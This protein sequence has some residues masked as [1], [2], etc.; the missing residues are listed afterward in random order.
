MSAETTQEKIE[1]T[2]ETTAEGSAETPEEQITEETELQTPSYQE[3]LSMARGTLLRNCISGYDWEIPT[4][5]N[6]TVSFELYGHA[7]VDQEENYFNSSIMTNCDLYIP[8][9]MYWEPV[10][11]D[12]FE[13]QFVCADRMKYSPE[14]EEALRQQ[15]GLSLE[16]TVD[17]QV[18][19]DGQFRQYSGE[20]ALVARMCEQIIVYMGE[21]QAQLSK[22]AEGVIRGE[23][24]MINQPEETHYSV[25]ELWICLEEVIPI[26]VTLHFDRTGDWWTYTK[27]F[28]AVGGFP[29]QV[30]EEAVIVINCD[31]V[32]EYKTSEEATD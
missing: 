21:L 32:V 27:N 30:R 1:A 12:E 28:N 8:G 31:L 5:E 15:P 6:E 7:A 3:I 17:I 25:A 22:S 16:G 19:G 23:A 10:G 24:Y 2:T 13:M 20:A 11:N 26:K 9:Q 4:D 29:E 14:R 18:P